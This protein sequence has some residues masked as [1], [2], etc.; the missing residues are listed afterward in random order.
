M[1]KHVSTSEKD[2]F[3]IKIK[4]RAQKKDG[5]AYKKRNH[6]ARFNL[7]EYIARVILTETPRKRYTPIV[8]M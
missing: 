2:S 5:K 7:H 8:Y 4:R 3:Q 6:S 1:C